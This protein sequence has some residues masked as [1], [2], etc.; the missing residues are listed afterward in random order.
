MIVGIDARAANTCAPLGVGV[1]CR[2][3]LR[4]MVALPCAPRLRLY[5]DANPCPDFP[6]SGDQ[7]DIRILPRRLAWTTL[8]LSKELSRDRPDVF[9]APVMQVPV[10]VRCPVIATCHGLPFL[11]YGASPN[12][13]RRALAVSRMLLMLWRCDRIVAVSDSMKSDMTNVLRA[14]TRK[15]AVVHHG[16]SSAFRPQHD[17]NTVQTV[18]DRYGLPE[19]YLLYCGRIGM[20]KN[21]VRLIEA[22]AHVRTRH[23]GLSCQLVLAGAPQKDAAPVI[24]AACHSTAKDAIRLLGYVERVDVPIVIAE[25]RALALVSL[26]ESFGMPALEGMASG[27]P[28]LASDR[29]ALP[30]ICGDAAA[31]VDPTST[32]AIAAGME[33]ILVDEPFRRALRDAGIQR[34]PQFSWEQTAIETL[35]LVHDLAASRHAR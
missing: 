27:T 22:F 10:G 11:K 3:L 34:A 28:V 4:A 5:L 33:R 30:E 21:L 24:E 29:G 8:Q 31:F 26:W 15:V 23:P 7:V 12:P 25:A 6:V 19:T 20:H 16:Y 13:A 18:R 9:F 17:A 1:Y 14:S 2:E 35:K 32:D